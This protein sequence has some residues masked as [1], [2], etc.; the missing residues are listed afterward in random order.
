MDLSWL[1]GEDLYLALS[2]VAAIVILRIVQCDDWSRWLGGSPRVTDLFIYPVKSCA[3]MKVKTARMMPRGFEGDRRFQCTDSAGKYCTPRDDDKAKLFHIVPTLTAEELVLTAPGQREPLR[4]N[5]PTAK[6]S[7]VDVEVLCAPDKQRLLDYGDAA[8]AWLERS[9]GIA[10]VRLSGQPKDS[11]RVC[12]VNPGQGDS[13][14]TAD[15]APVSLADEAP[16]LLTSSESLA[17][18]NKRLAARGKPAVDMRRFRPNIVISGLKPWEED[19]IRRVSIGGVEF[20][21]WQRCG[22]CKMTTIDRDTLA[23]GPEPLATL[24]TFRERANGQRNFGMHLIP[25]NAYK[26]TGAQIWCGGEVCVLE[27]DKE[28]RKEW[29]RLFG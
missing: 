19:C 8:G 4:L 24:N 25:V 3:E 17:D 10:G 15:D 29:Q 26:S 21:A 22:R 28:R 9:T 23:C 2:I 5:L 14:P 11:K 20:W 6:T 16:Y 7:P 18:L 12:V 13:I 1:G 27:Y